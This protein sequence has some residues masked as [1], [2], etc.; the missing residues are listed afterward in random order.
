MESYF[1]KQRGCQFPWNKDKNLGLRT[2]SDYSEIY[3]IPHM[4]DKAHG[5]RRERWSKYA[6]LRKTNYACPTPC[7]SKHYD[8]KI[9][10]WK[11]DVVPEEKK[12][13][14]Q[15]TF[16]DFVVSQREEY[17]GCDSTC[18]LGEIGGYLGFF[19]GGSVLVGIDIVLRLISDVHGKLYKTINS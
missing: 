7:F 4:F 14:L 1:Y 19:L 5:Y 13:S 6:R 11:N 9:E 10:T 17:I 12:V 3:S 8:V 18:I 16:E 2:C 15:I